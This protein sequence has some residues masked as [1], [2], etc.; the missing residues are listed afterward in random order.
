MYVPS[1][2]HPLFPGIDLA[3]ARR[4][5]LPALSHPNPT[6]KVKNESS[7]SPSSLRYLAIARGN[8]LDSSVGEMGFSDIP[9]EES[10]NGMSC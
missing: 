6:N 2:P 7:I 3:A 5:P 1:T 4:R 8:A 9:K 10:R